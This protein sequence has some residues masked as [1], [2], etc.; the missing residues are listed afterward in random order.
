MGRA[1]DDGPIGCTS[2]HAGTTTFREFSC[3][4]C[5][6]H[7]A[8]LINGVHAGI[9]R[10]RFESA[11]C[12]SCHPR[13]NADVA[14]DEATHTAQYFPIDAASTHADIRC[15]ECH[16][17]E[18]DRTVVGCTSCHEHEALPMQEVHGTMPG[19]A[20]DSPT[21]LGCHDRAQNPGK[22][23]H[24][25]FPTSTGTS[26]EGIACADCHATRQ[27]RS[28]LACVTCHEH[29]QPIVDEQ[30]ANVPDY[31]YDS[32]SCIL[33]HRQS[34]VPG[35][36]DHV[37]FPIEAPATHALG[38]PVDNAGFSPNTT[39]ACASCHVEP[40]DRSAI[41]CVACHAHAEDVLATTHTG[42]D[43]YEWTSAR[44]V[45]CHP[46]GEPTGLID[47]PQFPIATGAAHNGVSCTECHQSTTNRSLLGCT[48][49]HE[50]TL[51]LTEPVHR[52]M[53]GFTFDSAACVT[54]HDQAQVPGR[55]DHENLFP[56][57]APSQH[58]GLS[59]RDCHTNPATRTTL[60]CTSCHLGTH[61]EAPMAQV[62]GGIPDY[63][64]TP[65][66]CVGCHP[67][68]SAENA[69]FSH[70]YF[71]IATGAVH[72]GFACAD[73][74]TTPGD[75]TQVSCTTCHVGTHDEQPMIAT[76]AAVPGFQWSTT[77][78]LFCHP[79]SEPT[80]AID[81]EAYFPLNAPAAHNGIACADCHTDPNNRL[82]LGCAAC[83]A[84]D[85]P[86]V[87]TVHAGIPGFVNNSPACLQ[88]HP[89]AEPV[90]AMDHNP[91]FPIASGTAHGGSGYSGKVSS[92]ETQCTACHLSRTDRSQ[93][94][95]AAC[96]AGVSPTPS[97]AHGSVNGFSNTSPK[98]KECHADAQVNRLAAHSDFPVRHHGADC[99][100]CHRQ[101]RTDKPFGIN[102]SRADCARCHSSSCT[103][104]NQGPCD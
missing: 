70:P 59:C 15:S 93:N 53:P 89:R 73:C 19:Y 20:W 74:H 2:C 85:N 11:S 51:E 12:L 43:G 87:T 82:V 88:C 28:A 8:E 95:C 101:M 46:S 76:H 79:N 33:C 7:R 10:Y 56:L 29:D 65:A 22:L 47:H 31:A 6:E 39:I 100:E 49:C 1:A 4:G 63:S 5:H 83:H 26:H 80:G 38:T 45:F 58:A 92:G 35:A 84:S 42:I 16:T 75:N 18:A 32:G 23:E 102:F 60:S 44:C 48:S 3:V 54:C 66:S 103:P 62:H 64:W 97:Q 98:C 71:P 94:D 55:F 21:C 50:H 90:G 99:N 13:G 34:Q 61:D 67:T 91:W 40:T 41:G 104:S 81:H 77:Q 9:A 25:Y 86:S 78:C 72:A 14:I 24:S 30:H 52:S 57:N 36:I 68:G 17:N 69:V 37:F 96:H 27:D